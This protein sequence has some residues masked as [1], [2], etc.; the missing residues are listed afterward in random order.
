MF[1]NNTEKQELDLVDRIL[2]EVN[3]S[4]YCSEANDMM[5]RT[6]WK[7][8]AVSS[9]A[10]KLVE[11]INILVESKAI[12]KNIYSSAITDFLNDKEKVARMREQ[13]H[14]VA[15]D[16]GAKKAEEEIHA[17]IEYSSQH[18]RREKFF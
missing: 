12:P 13:A 8:L 16:Y 7:L 1:H 11:I 5:I 10:K 18:Y 14:K 9:N 17:A 6:A 15:L 4:K 2:H 3:S